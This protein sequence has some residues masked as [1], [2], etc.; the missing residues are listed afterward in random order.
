MELWVVQSNYPYEETPVYGLF[1]SLTD[2]AN[3]FEGEWFETADGWLNEHSSALRAYPMEV[4]KNY[5]DS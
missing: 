1:P 5:K 2:V 3:T 4:G